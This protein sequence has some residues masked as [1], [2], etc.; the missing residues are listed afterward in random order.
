MARQTFFDSPAGTH[1]P[2]IA[3]GTRALLSSSRRALSVIQERRTFWCSCTYCIESFSQSTP[4]TS[5][6]HFCYHFDPILSQVT[7]NRTP[8]P[9]HSLSDRSPPPP[10]PP[11]PNLSPSRYPNR[12]ITATET[13]AATA[14]SPSL[15]APTPPHATLS[16]CVGVSL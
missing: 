5:T 2:M 9:A 1:P 12:T 11:F 6:P 4:I 13:A 10:P 8:R 16:L 14:P 15:P 7:F 3:A